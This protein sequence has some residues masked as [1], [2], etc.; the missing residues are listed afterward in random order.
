MHPKCNI[1]IIVNGAKF[2]NASPACHFSSFYFKNVAVVLLLT[3]T[4]LIGVLF[5][6][7]KI[8]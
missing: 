2:F 6:H 5:S 8:A 7:D 1:C 4:A 3:A